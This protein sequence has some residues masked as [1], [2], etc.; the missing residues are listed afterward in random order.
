M[1]WYYINDPYPF[2]AYFYKI[3]YAGNLGK[4]GVFCEG[5]Y[6]GPGV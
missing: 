3:I 2:F 4:N 1:V 5:G 6:F